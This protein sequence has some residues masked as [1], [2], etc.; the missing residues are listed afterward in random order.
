MFIYSFQQEFDTPAITAAGDISSLEQFKLKVGKF[1]Q[2]ITNPQPSVSSP[3]SPITQL[4]A[5]QSSYLPELVKP[6]FTPEEIQEL[7]EIFKQ[8]SALNFET[9]AEGNLKVHFNICC[10]AAWV[11]KPASQGLHTQLLAKASELQTKVNQLCEI[12]EKHLQRE[13]LQALLLSAKDEAQKVV[14]SYDQD[15]I[16]LVQLKEEE[17]RLEEALLQVREKITQTSSSMQTSMTQASSTVVIIKDLE[18]QLQ[19]ATDQKEIYDFVC[20][21]G[22]H[23][24]SDLKDVIAQFLSNE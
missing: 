5:K 4:K 19:R 6:T 8:F 2:K 1:C 9:L 22:A 18:T 21:R 11:L 3:E 12:Q 10:Q 7:K 24:L 14:S 15:A 16:R 17:A 20:N 23:V 13:N